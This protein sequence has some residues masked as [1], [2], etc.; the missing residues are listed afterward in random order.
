MIRWLALTLGALGLLGVVLSGCYAHG[1]GPFPSCTTL[2]TPP[3]CYPPITD[4]RV[5][6]DGGTR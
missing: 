2:P 6:R 1:P 4:A 3:G 5:L